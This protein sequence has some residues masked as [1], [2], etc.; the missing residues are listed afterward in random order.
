MRATRRFIKSLLY[1][2]NCDS[3]LAAARHRSLDSMSAIM[4][5]LFSLAEHEFGEIQFAMNHALEI[6]TGQ[7]MS[8]A[9]CMYLCGFER[10][11][12]L[13][14]YRQLDR[15]A[16]RESISNATLTRR[17]ISKYQS[18]DNVNRRLMRIQKSDLGSE[19]FKEIGIEYRAPYDLTTSSEFNNSQDLV[20]SYTVLEHVPPS[21]LNSLIAA[22]VQTC[23]E[24]G[25]IIH[26]VDLEDHKDALKRPFDFLSANGAWEEEMAYSRGN[27]IR[28]SRWREMFSMFSD[29]E[30][31]YPYIAQRWDPP[32]PEKIDPLIEF[33]NEED[34]RITAFV[35][36]GRKRV[37][38]MRENE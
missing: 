35:V 19:F 5:W 1:S 10:I 7:F 14:K 16:M 17:Y 12:T 2:P 23:K 26:F 33:S 8:H 27:R 30:W 37:K 15:T 28:Y 11:V 3:L 25:L 22:S 21:E 36:V 13:D 9:I 29:I 6:G 18:N 38:L 34:L 20:F 24:N 4:H 31:R 32:I